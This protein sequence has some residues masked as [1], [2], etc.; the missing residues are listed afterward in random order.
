VA[1]LPWLH[2]HPFD[3]VLV[4][5]A[6]SSRLRLLTADETVASYGDPVLLAK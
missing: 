5:Q 3:R 4:A 1:R 6:R 2:R